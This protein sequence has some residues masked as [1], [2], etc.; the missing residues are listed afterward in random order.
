MWLDT[1]LFSVSQAEKIGLHYYF[2]DERILYMVPHHDLVDHP[3]TG[4]FHLVNHQ[5]DP[6]IMRLDHF[7]LFP[8]WLELRPDT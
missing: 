1:I 7:A 4:A 5:E 8:G 3:I 6:I 2:F